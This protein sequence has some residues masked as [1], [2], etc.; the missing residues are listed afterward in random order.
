[1]NEDAAIV[2]INYMEE[3]LFEPKQNWPKDE[4]Y[5]RSYSRWAANEILELVLK[6]PFDAAHSLIEGF[7]FQMLYFSHLSK[8]E[9]ANLIFSIAMET[10]EDILLLFL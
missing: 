6:H 3:N 5:R 4:F 9:S 7:F 10:A 8:S 1:M 2:I